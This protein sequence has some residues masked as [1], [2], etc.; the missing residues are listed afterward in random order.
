MSIHRYEHGRE[1]PNLREGDYDFT[2]D[3]P[4]KGYNMNVPLNEVCKTYPLSIYLG[5]KLVSSRLGF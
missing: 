4:G 5:L 3:G 1:W 2:G